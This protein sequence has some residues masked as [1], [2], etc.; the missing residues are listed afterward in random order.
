MSE[1]TPPKNRG[2][3]VDLHSAALL[4][5][6]AS[7]AWTSVGFY[8][9]HPAANNQWRAPLALQCLPP[10]IVLSFMYWLPESPRWLVQNDRHE[11]ARRI[12][13]KLHDRDEATIEM[14]QIKTQIAVENTLETSW[15]SLLRKR[16]YRKRTW[17][18]LGTSVGIQM[19]GVLVI[20]SMLNPF[21]YNYPPFPLYS[22]L[23]KLTSLPILIDY[24]PT[25]YAGLGF[26]KTQ[27]LLYQGGFNTL[28]FGSGMLALLI[29]DRVPR[30]RL[31]S[32]GAAVVLA[33]LIAEAALVAS[34]PP[35]P[36]QNKD[37]LRAALA[38]LFLYIVSSC[39][40]SLYLDVHRSCLRLSRR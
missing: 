12:L 34:Y 13:L 10:T 31:I 26:T 40:F 33:T 38:M 2:V 28:A 8:F 35:G 22:L 29:I 3:F 6:Y 15:M 25:I 30:H 4:F 1:V 17:I 36:D 5:G 39:H 32:I 21:N 20:N 16:S 7:A 11:D 14:E 23:L 27:Q 18:T 37:A 19:T 9:Y 24:G